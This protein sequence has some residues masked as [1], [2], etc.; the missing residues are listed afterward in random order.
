MDLFAFSQIEDLSKIANANGINVPRL[1]GYRLMADE[2]PVTEE[3]IHEMIQKQA[4]E[5]AKDLCVSNW[6]KNIWHSYCKRTDKIRKKYLIRQT[7]EE[8]KYQEEIGIRW[9]RI[10]GKRRK[11]L[12]WNIRKAER[13]IRD[14][15]ALWNKYAG[16]T[17]ILY[18]HARIGGNNWRWYEAETT[19]ANQPW[20]LAKVDDCWDP[21]YCDI[22][23][24]LQ[25]QKDTE[26][27]V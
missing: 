6:G 16:Q 26:G 22:Y 19:V 12:K 2:K 1:R 23:A 20:F 25:P 11:L 7:S 18:I 15:Y 5:E 21:T 17:D 24:K 3:E 13:R 10:H 14:Q 4:V 9:D 27:V 8:N